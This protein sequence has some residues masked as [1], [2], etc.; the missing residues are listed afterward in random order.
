MVEWVTLRIVLPL[1]A[2]AA[3][4]TALRVLR[5]P[6]FPDRVVGLDL[7]ATIGIGLA[8]AWAIVTGESVF[9][10]AALVIA[11]IAFLAVIAF[12]RYLERQG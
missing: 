3:V 8:A 4:L 10:D 1:L 2:A 5:G 6:S 12:A 11:L 7:L 9:L